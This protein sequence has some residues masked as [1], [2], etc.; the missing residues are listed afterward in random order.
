MAWHLSAGGMFRRVLEVTVGV[1]MLALVVDVSWQVLTRYS[2]GEPSAW[3]DELATIL[4]IWVACLGSA[5]G[6]VRGSHLGVDYFTRFLPP[7]IAS[8]QR[9]FVPCAVLFFA[10]AV[11]AYGGYQLVSVTLSTEQVSPALGL[12]MG[13]VYMALP[14]SGAFIVAHSMEQAYRQWAALGA[15]AP[16]LSKSG[17]SH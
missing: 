16:A 14:L 17:R 5:L 8:W 2:F 6:F 4:M 3:T 9:I 11:L 10:A 1:L 12:K 15:E 7:A 13:H